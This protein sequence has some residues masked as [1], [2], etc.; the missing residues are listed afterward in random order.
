M[1]Y[2]VTIGIPVYNVERYIRQTLE[3]VLAQSFK[4]IEFLICDD[5]C[6][7]SSIAIVEE[8]QRNHSRGGDIRI[9][10][11]SQNQGVGFAR[12]R[13]IEESR[14]KYI[15]FIDSDDLIINNAIELLYTYAITYNADV[16][17]GSMDK[18]L[19][20]A[21]NSVVHNYNYFF[22]VFLKENEFAEFVYRKYDGIQASSC[23]MLIKVSIFRQYNI[24]YFQINYWEDM[25]MALDLP[26]YISRAVLLPNVT[27]YYMCRAGTLSNYQKRE[28]INKAEI[29]K[30][31]EAVEQL[32]NNSCFFKRNTCFS[33]RMFKLMMTCFYIVCAVFRNEALI[34]PSFTN[35]ELRD[36]M[37][38]PLSFS[39]I[40]CLR[41]KRL[42]N[43]LLYLFGVLPPFLSVLSM[44]VI[45]KLKKV[46]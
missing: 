3:S 44:R 25:L 36:L 34:T 18:I 1:E 46:I 2:E 17:Y 43:I 16:V 30:I 7:D 9:L 42:M 28:R 21:D 11:Q 5:C 32:K 35:T 41:G 38:N 20:Y 4:N 45:A 23:N 19:L 6:T 14:G 26:Y 27:Y 29:L 8:Y 24:R 15:F 13:I 10:H 39:E 37:N 40:L 31:I 12:N 22:S 33:G